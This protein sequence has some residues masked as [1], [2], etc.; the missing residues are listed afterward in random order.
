MKNALFRGQTG[1][2]RSEEEEAFLLLLTSFTLSYTCL[3]VP[4][5]TDAIRGVLSSDVQFHLD[6]TCTV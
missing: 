3:E 6:E 4:G 5:D 2:R 1:V